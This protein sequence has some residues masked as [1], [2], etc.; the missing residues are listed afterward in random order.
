MEPACMQAL[1]S[2]Q[3]IVD[4]DELGTEPEPVLWPRGFSGRLMDGRGELVAPDG[5]VV[6]RDRETIE[7]VGG[8]VD[9]VFLVCSVD[10]V[11]YG[12]AS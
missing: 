10:G 8:W 4:G 2:G 3:L 7:A 1:Y 5:T 11:Q 12:P 9:G 6:G